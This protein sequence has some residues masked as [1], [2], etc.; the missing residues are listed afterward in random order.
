M[1]GKGERRSAWVVSLK[2]IESA[3]TAEA[4]LRGRDLMEG[5]VYGG[6]DY[7][8]SGMGWCAE[9]LGMERSAASLQPL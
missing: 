6:N 2:L 4:D 7:A 9:P 3:F 8:G 1:V 5:S